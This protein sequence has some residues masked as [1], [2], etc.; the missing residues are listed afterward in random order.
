ML[1]V[2]RLVFPV[3]FIRVEVRYVFAFA[4]FRVVSGR[5]CM[6]V[7]ECTFIQKVRS[8]IV[9]SSYTIWSYFARLFLKFSHMGACAYVCVFTFGECHCMSVCAH[10]ERYAGFEYS[11]QK[12]WSLIVNLYNYRLNCLHKMCGCRPPLPHSNK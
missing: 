10:F 8:D 3:N 5:V 12:I 1:L 6:Y 9:Y 11:M 7:C 2:F 4:M